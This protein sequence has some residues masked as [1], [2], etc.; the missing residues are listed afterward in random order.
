M[1]SGAASTIRE[2]LPNPRLGHLLTPRSYGAAAEADGRPWG[3]DNGAFT[4]FDPPK[5][6]RMVAAVAKFPGCRFVVCPDVVGDAA[7]TLSLFGQWE[8]DLHNAGVPVAFVGQDGQERLAV[9]WDACEAFFVGGS[10]AWKLGDEA[11]ALV[12]EARR[13]GKWVHMGRVSTRRRLAYAYRLGCDSVDSTA[14]GRQPRILRCALRW[15]RDIERQP[16]LF[17]GVRGG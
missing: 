9:P 8:P 13:R 1:V 14:F 5:F 11:A 12:E 3:A 15:L 7:G 6:R 10:T 16:V 17:E 2:H 4:G